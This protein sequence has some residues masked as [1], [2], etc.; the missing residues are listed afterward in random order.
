MPAMP[1]KG[2]NLGVNSESAMVV[3][4]AGNNS[5]AMGEDCERRSKSVSARVVVI[6]DLLVVHSKVEIP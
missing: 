6:D 4:L 3:A 1:R 2:A 5:A